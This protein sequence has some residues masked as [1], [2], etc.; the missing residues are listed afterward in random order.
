MPAALADF[1][2]LVP[3][4]LGSLQK[5]EVLSAPL[6]LARLSGREWFDLLERKL[7]PQLGRDS[8]L[9]V[10]VTGGTNIGKSVVFNHLAGFRASASSPLASGTKH[11][12]CLAPEDF[13]R[14]HDLAAIF[15]TFQLRPWAEAS[16]ALQD[17]DEHLLFWRTSPD[18]PANLLLLDTPDAGEIY[19]HSEALKNGNQG[20]A[21]FADVKTLQSQRKEATAF[22]APAEFSADVMGPLSQFIRL[23]NSSAEGSQALLAELTQNIVVVKT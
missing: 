11:P 17:S 3:R 12:V 16:E 14:R 2:E 5:L 4:L 10:A 23:Q 6:Q 13:Q 9:V 20:R 22:Q 21:S 15:P 19:L 18:V 1:A 7:A 8:F